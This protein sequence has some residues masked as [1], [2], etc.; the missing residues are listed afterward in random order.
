MEYFAGFRRNIIPVLILAIIFSCS[1]Q[2]NLDV[3]YYPADFEPSAST[4]FIWTTDFYE[5]IPQVAGIISQKDRVT[6]YADESED[7]NLIHQVLEKHE[8]NLNNITIVTVKNKPQNAW[9]RDFGPVY[10]GNR[11]GEKKIISFNYFGKSISFNE[12]LAGKLN[13][14]HDYNALNSSGGS[15][16][17]NGKGTLILCEQHELSVNKSR[18]LTE[19]E[20]AYFEAL[21]I[22]KVIWLKKGIPQDDSELEGPLFDQIYPNGVNGHVDE[23]CRF[24]DGKTVLISSVTESEAKKHPIFAEAKNRLDEN[25]EI[26]VNS[27]DQ[28][29]NKFNI[30]KVPF[31]PLLVFERPEGET[32]KYMTLVTS[33]MNFIVTNS[34]VIMP[35]YVSSVNKSDRKRVA[36]IEDQV[37]NIL[38]NAFPLK[39]IIRLPAGDLNRFSGG[40]HCISIN[41]PLF[42]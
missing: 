12:Q 42:K 35:S 27:S 37:K 19:I 17:T 23:F 15:R 32:L 38:S 30:I 2:Q 18:S 40:F 34:M 28:D 36:A 10:L 16:E 7:M 3:F 5:I 6:L 13:V 26:L 4:C 14:P 24:V 9:I 33:Y 22:K 8:G 29:G 41:E 21:N 20:K 25:Y 11:K 31:A 39:E 1:R